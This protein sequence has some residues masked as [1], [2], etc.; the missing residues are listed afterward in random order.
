LEDSASV[1]DGDLVVVLAI[2]SVDCC[3][4]NKGKLLKKEDLLW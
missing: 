4:I 3:L 2:V 1:E